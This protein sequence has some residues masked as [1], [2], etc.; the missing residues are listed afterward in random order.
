MLAGRV[1][2]TE[3]STR[4][5]PRP[6]VRRRTSAATSC[7]P[8]VDGVVGP[9]GAQA[10][11]LLGARRGGQHRGPGPVGQLEGGQA[12]AST[13]GLDEDRL[14]LGQVAELEEAVVGGA[15]GDRHAGRGHQ[16][17]PLGHEPGERRRHHDLL[18]VGAVHHGGHD[19]LAHLPVGDLGPDLGDGAPALVA[20]DVGH[21][22]HLALEAVQGVAALDADGLHLDAHPVRRERG[23]G[24]VLVAEHVRRSGL[25][26]H[27]CLHGGISSWSSTRRRYGGRPR[28]APR[29]GDAATVRV[30]LATRLVAGSP[31]P[32][33]QRPFA[34]LW[35]R[36]WSPVRG[37]R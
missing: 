6:S 19:L 7:G 4:S 16:V 13:S 25:V 10:L 15:E 24:D 35:R 37:G 21:G 17:E 32:T 3:S 28:T 23:V 31:P 22:G 36:V 8:V 5:T 34:S 29:P 18:G 33:K 1:E 30:A 2:P 20:H 11:E 26:V 27:G 9:V 12:H 14:A